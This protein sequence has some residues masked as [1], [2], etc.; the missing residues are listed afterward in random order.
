MA[1]GEDNRINSEGRSGADD[2]AD[3]VRVG[4]LIEHEDK[5][6]FGQILK[7]ERRQ[8][9]GFNREALMNSALRQEPI[10]LIP[11]H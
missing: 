6:L 3:I 10:K 5:A 4:D 8:G 1:F 11:P 9:L 2:R 7:R